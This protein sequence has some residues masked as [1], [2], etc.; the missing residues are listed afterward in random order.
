MFA[1]ESCSP[2]GPSSHQL[3]LTA[4]VSEPLTLKLAAVVRESFCS[5]TT[6]RCE[7]ESQLQRWREMRRP[8]A[9]SPTRVPSRAAGLAGQRSACTT[10][11]ADTQPSPAAPVDITIAHQRHSY[12]NRSTNT[13]GCWLLNSTSASSRSHAVPDACPAAA[14]L[15]ASPALLADPSSPLPLC[16]DGWLGCWSGDIPEPQ[17]P[18]AGL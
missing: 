12:F 3:R 11:T 6:Q 9:A 10:N 16:H 15:S 2:C 18:S 17:R 8:F 1:R 5:I 7:T 14:E 4:A 13:D